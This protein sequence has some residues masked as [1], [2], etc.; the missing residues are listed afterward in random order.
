MELV[1]RGRVIYWRGPAPWNFV[2]LA[3]EHSDLLVARTP[4]L[5]YGWGC[6]PVDARIAGEAFATSLMPRHGRFLLPLR[7]AVRTRL[8]LEPG[9]VADYSLLV[10]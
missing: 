2:E 3:E 7:A 5:S 6:I 10:G 9:D 4:Q 1:G 8:G